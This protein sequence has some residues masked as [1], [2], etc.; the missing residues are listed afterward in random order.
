MGT[1]KPYGDP[2]VAAAP[3]PDLPATPDGAAWRRCGTAR[4]RWSVIDLYDLHYYVAGSTGFPDGNYALEAAYL[5]RIP[6][7]TLRDVTLDEL[8]RADKA[9]A[10]D[11]GSIGDWLG[12]AYADVVRGDR[13]LAIVVAGR[14]SILL[15]GQS[16]AETG[17]ARLARAFAGIWLDSGARD[18]QL[19][20][21][22]LQAGTKA[23]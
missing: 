23:R 20:D 1:K 9:G 10:L 15:N 18:A 17:D 5:R 7:A 2:A 8:R 19:R 16:R 14:L 3:W 12:S 6:A 13:L 21:A 4:V 11:F 22:L